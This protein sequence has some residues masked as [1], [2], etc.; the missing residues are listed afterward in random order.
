MQIGIVGLPMAGKTTVFNLLTG[1]GAPAGPGADFPGNRDEGTIG[2]AKVPDERIDYL[3]NMF[4]PRKTTYAQI[5]VTD[6][7]GLVRSAG[8]KGDNARGQANM[9]LKSIQGVDA[10]VHV[11][12]AFPS[13]DI[14]HMDGSVDPV[15]DFDAVNMELILSDLEI[16]YKTLER[17]NGGGGGAGRGP[18][19]PRKKIKLEPGQLEALEKCRVALEAEKPVRDASLTGEEFL[20]LKGFGFLTAKPLVTVI[21]MGEEHLKTGDYPGRA[22]LRLRAANARSPLVELSA[23]IEAEIASL[24]DEDDQAAFMQDFG[25]S[26]PGIRKLARACYDALGLISFFTVGED[27]VKAWTIKNGTTAKAAAGKIHSDIEKGFIRAEVA[28]FDDLKLH[29]SIAALKEKGLYR[30]EGK[31]YIVA[32]G[33]IISF[34]FNV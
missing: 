27:E 19:G 15:R 17:V 5:R 10:V 26:E 34:R 25:I 16:V 20:L 23:R 14:P 29:G 7:P 22:E 1:M 11:I 2:M 8:V 21:N 4:K 31:D 32:D 3:H 24:D 18:A 9:F 28:G 6:L 30:L 12:R 13:P 33:D